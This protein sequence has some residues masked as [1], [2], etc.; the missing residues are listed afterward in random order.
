[1]TP[2][3]DCLPGAQDIILRK[4]FETMAQERD[5]NNMKRVGLNTQFYLTSSTLLLFHEAKK[6]F[7]E[8]WAAA[9]GPWWAGWD[10]KERLGLFSYLK[11][12]GP[13]SRGAGGK[14]QLDSRNKRDWSNQ[15]FLDKVG[16]KNCEECSISISYCQEPCVYRQP[17]G[18]E[19]FLMQIL[20]SCFSCSPLL[21]QLKKRFFKV[22]CFKEDW[23]KSAAVWLNWIHMLGEGAG[24]VKALVIS[25]QL[26]GE[27]ETPVRVQMSGSV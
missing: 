25:S 5:S 9:A 11:W 23:L 27:N 18:C 4:T 8:T 19:V 22:G 21:F 3:W 2:G 20:L 17:S 12:S 16:G 14:V 24:L 7:Q 6:H 26:V 15:C 13:S 1:M 10:F